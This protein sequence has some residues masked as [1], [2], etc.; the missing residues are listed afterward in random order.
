MRHPAI[1]ATCSG[2]P[3][4]RQERALAG[5]MVAVATALIFAR[6][7]GILLQGR[8][9]AEEAV[10][11][12][13]DAMVGTWYE[14]I[15]AP[16]VG[17]FSAFNKL[18]ALAASA[19]PLEEA[20]HVTTVCA[21]AVQLAVVWIIARSD[22]FG[23]LWGRALAALAPLLAVPSVEVWLNTIN[24]QFH[25]A[26]GAAVLLATGR[27]ALPAPFRLVFLLLAGATGPVSVS[28]APLFALKAFRTRAREDRVEA[29]L[30]CALALVQG[31]LLAHSLAGGERAGGISGAALLGALG[32]KNLALPWL[33]P[34]A[35]VLAAELLADAP[36]ADALPVKGLIGTGLVAFAACL[37]IALLRSPASRWLTGAALVIAIVSYAGALGK[38]PW[39]LLIPTA[40]GRYAYAPNVLILLA[41]VAAAAAQATPRRIRLLAGALAGWVL[42]GG[43]AQFWSDEDFFRGPSWSGAVAAWRADPTGNRIAI[44]PAPWFLTLP[45]P[46]P[47]AAQPR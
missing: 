27:S 15:L 14:A 6:T 1:P 36:P 10:I 23:P 20:A 38:D 37:A 21:L 43:L 11:Y 32:I 28:L 12:F 16:R 35:Q 13:R 41:L 8:M 33:G 45:H 7:P 19:V 5:L 26:I 25:L 34:W 30:L 4:S 39:I 9:F 18:A 29:A 42:I 17:Y 47:G 46:A 22:A 40:S 2:L 31:L 3:P 44:W 24:S